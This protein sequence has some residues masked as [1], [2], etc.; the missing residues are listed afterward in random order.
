MLIEKEVSLNLAEE[1]IKFLELTL[2]EVKLIPFYFNKIIN[3]F[4]IWKV[5]VT[6][7]KIHQTE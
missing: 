6:I 5:V 4:E 1:K 3:S 2:N 7:K